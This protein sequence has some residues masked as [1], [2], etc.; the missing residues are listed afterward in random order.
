M[1]SLIENK[2]KILRIIRIKPDFIFSV[3]AISGSRDV[4]CDAGMFMSIII[5]T[6]TR[7][8]YDGKEMK[9]TRHTNY[10]C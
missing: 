7:I 3:V 6:K 1:L 8:L 10:V 9:K 2:K 4:S 5:N